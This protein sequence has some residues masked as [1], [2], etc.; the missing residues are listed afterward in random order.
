MN[1]SSEKLGPIGT[2]TAQSDYRPV[3]IVREAA[4]ELDQLGFTAIWYPESLGCESLTN[5]AL[6]LSATSQIVVASGIVECD[7]QR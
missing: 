6:L 5:A 1:S 3:A 4:G 7:A 2:W